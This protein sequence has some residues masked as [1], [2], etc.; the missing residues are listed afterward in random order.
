MSNTFDP[1][2]VADEDKKYITIGKA[3]EL[4]GVSRMSIYRILEDPNTAMTGVKI[5][6]SRRI[7]LPS[8]YAYMQQLERDAARECPECERMVEGPR[9][10]HCDPKF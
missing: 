5:G 7:S 1:S 6:T 9:C 2:S 3:M 4:L 8:V 10:P